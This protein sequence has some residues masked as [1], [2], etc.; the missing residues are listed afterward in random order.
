M[1][2]VSANAEV[3][4]PSCR[5]TEWKVVGVMS[6]DLAYLTFIKENRVHILS[7]TCT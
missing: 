1:P 3:V 4:C 2:T 5:N 6:G 7:Q